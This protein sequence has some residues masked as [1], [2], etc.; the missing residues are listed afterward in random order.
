[1]WWW[2]TNR[3]KRKWNQ[4]GI[5]KHT[6]RNTFENKCHIVLGTSGIKRSNGA[7]GETE[8]GNE[9]KTKRK[10]RK[11]CERCW[12][13]AVRREKKSFGDRHIKSAHD[14][15]LRAIYNMR[16]ERVGTSA[17]G[18]ITVRHVNASSFSSFLSDITFSSR[19]VFYPRIAYSPAYTIHFTAFPRFHSVSRAT[20]P[21]HS[22]AQSLALFS[23]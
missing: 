18:D 9:A 12:A 3:I 2:P 7:N 6:R 21:L 11:K 5:H 8:N 20:S 10:P 1:M 19:C 13:T 4:T 17:D 15:H 23:N 14:F 22:P 16:D